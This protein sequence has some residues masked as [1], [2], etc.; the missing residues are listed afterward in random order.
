MRYLLTFFFFATTL[1]GCAFFAKHPED[2]QYI[3]HIVDQ[4]ITDVIVPAQPVE[5]GTESA[6]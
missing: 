3:E 4:A 5:T 1:T 2:V 6:V